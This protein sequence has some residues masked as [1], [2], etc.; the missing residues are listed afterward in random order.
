MESSYWRAQTRLNM[1]SME[2]FCFCER[3]KTLNVISDET[4][5]RC[6]AKEK[7]KQNI[8]DTESSNGEVSIFTK[9]S[10]CTAHRGLAKVKE[11]RKLV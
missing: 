5:P 6:T 2:S 11:Q 7:E 4:V 1:H 8:T 10:V 9:T 3:S